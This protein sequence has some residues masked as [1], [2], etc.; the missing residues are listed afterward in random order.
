[1]PMITQDVTVVPLVPNKKED[2]VKE[3]VKNSKK[4]PEEKT[5]T[6]P[7]AKGKHTKKGKQPIA[8]NKNSKKEKKPAEPKFIEKTQPVMDAV[9]E[10]AITY[11]SR[12]IFAA[13]DNNVVINLPHFE[14]RKYVVKFFDEEERPMFELNRIKEDY[15]IVEKMN[16]LHS[17]WFYFEIYENGKMIEKNKFFIPRD[18]KISN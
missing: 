9:D 7:V 15:L 2:L 18:G 1:L 4:E 12:R 17:G 13:K 5:K 11:P 16:F 10:N 8:N 14:S 6:P 3:P